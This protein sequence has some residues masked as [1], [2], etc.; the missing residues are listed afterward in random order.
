MVIRCQRPLFKENWTEFGYF[1]SKLLQIF[2]PYL[3]KKI[4]MCLSIEMPSMMHPGRVT[5]GTKLM[6]VFT[7]Q[8]N[9]R[10]Q[11]EYSD[12]HKTS[13]WFMVHF[14]ST[15]IS[16][17]R[18]PNQSL[19]NKTMIDQDLIFTQIN[20]VPFRTNESLRNF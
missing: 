10:R 11:D 4:D 17:G 13:Q 3:K 14:Q 5:Q 2:A 20:D 12:S 7:I 19:Q 16:L 18:H 9:P 6:N 15:S 1:H 8:K